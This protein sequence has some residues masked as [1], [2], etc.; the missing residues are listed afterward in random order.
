MVRMK[1]L[2]V[3][4]GMRLAYCLASLAALGSFVGKQ[5]TTLFSLRQNPLGFKPLFIQKNNPDTHTGIGITWCGCFY[6]NKP[7]TRYFTGF[8]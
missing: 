4:C 7:K 8:V 1:G 2:A 3:C 5:C 6:G